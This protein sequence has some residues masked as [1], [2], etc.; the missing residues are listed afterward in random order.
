MG[1]SSSNER[2]S[3]AIVDSKAGS[4]VPARQGSAVGNM[5]WSDNKAPQNPLDSYHVPTKKRAVLRYNPIFRHIHMFKT[6]I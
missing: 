3:I 1:K 5:A 6:H 2:F 4:R